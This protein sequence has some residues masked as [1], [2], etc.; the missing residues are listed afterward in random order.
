MKLIYVVEPYPVELDILVWC[1]VVHRL[2]GV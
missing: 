2:S 1:A